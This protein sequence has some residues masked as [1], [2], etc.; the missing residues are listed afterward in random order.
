MPNWLDTGGHVEGTI[1]WRFLLPV[2]DPE[3][4]ECVVLPVS[5]VSG[6]E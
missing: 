1:F 4:P 3:K 5:E 6:T 2:H